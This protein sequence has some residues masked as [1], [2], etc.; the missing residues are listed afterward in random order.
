MIIRFKNLKEY[1]EYNPGFK[2]KKRVAKALKKRDGSSISVTYL[3]MLIATDQ[4][5]PNKQKDHF[6]SYSLACQIEELLNV[7]KESVLRK[8]PIHKSFKWQDRIFKTNKK[9]RK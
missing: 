9:R 2:E 6:A 4:N 8:P 7:P 3:Y 1:F 5:N